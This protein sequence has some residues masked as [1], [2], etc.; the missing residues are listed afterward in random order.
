MDKNKLAYLNERISPTF[1]ESSLTNT[2]IFLDEYFSTTSQFEP[3]KGCI[4]YSL[5]R[6]SLISEKINGI[7][8]G[9]HCIVAK[10]NIGKTTFLTCLAMDVLFSNIPHKPVKILFYTFD[11]TKED[12][13]QNIWA[14]LSN[15]EKLQGNAGITVH[16]D[17]VVKKR[18]IPQKEVIIS[19]SHDALMAFVDRKYFKLRDI[20][21]CGTFESMMSDICLE[22]SADDRIMVFVDGLANVMVETIKS[23]NK[24]AQNDHK[25][26]EIKKLCNALNIPVIIT[27]EVPKSAGYRPVKEDIKESVRYSFD[28]K[29]IICL[30]PV[31]DDAFKTRANPVVMM[32]FD[33]NKRGGFKGSVFATFR[34][35]LATYM[36]EPED[37]CDRFQNMADE[38]DLKRVRM[39]KR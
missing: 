27:C 4:G 3:I 31:N 34:G 17:E 39:G 18:H 30:S 16:K 2:K 23:E 6:Y 5:D 35:P 28:A 14:Y 38:Y 22:Y 12:I 15:Y 32:H 26:L 21:D 33:K 20:D 19:K 29:V 37:S 13:T 10:A 9:M 36:M 24:V 8:S 1:D 11:D 25:S 7:Q